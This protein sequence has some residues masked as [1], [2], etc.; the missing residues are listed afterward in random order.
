M[1]EHYLEFHLLD[2]QLILNC[3]H[4]LLPTAPH[5][6]E[7]WVC[8]LNLV[9]TII[10]HRPILNSNQRG[11]T[12]L[13]CQ[14]ITEK[15]QHTDTWQSMYRKPKFR[16]SLSLDDIAKSHLEHGTIIFVIIIV[17]CISKPNIWLKNDILS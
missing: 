15:L 1:F 9:H 6:P 4:S 7:T 2:Y 17:P 13:P 14:T 5:T 10:S 16:E 3:Y 8:S 12:L 11:H